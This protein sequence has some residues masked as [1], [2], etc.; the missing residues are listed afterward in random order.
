MNNLLS[1]FSTSKWKRSNAMVFLQKS[2]KTVITIN[3]KKIFLSQ[4]YNESAELFFNNIRAAI[5]IIG[6]LF[7]DVSIKGGGISSQFLAL[8]LAFSRAF[9]L[10]FPKKK[11]IFNQKKKIISISKKKERKKFGLKKARKKFQYSKR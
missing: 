4:K 5:K 10:I 11:L 6:S 7:I 1:A 9:C 8:N 2:K 3:G